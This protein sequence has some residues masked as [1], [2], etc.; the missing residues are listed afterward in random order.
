MENQISNISTD[1]IELTSSD[2]E[3]VSGGFGGGY[4]SISATNGSYSNAFGAGSITAGSAAG[5]G[6]SHAG[7]GGAYGASQSGSASAPGM[8]MSVGQGV[9]WAGGAGF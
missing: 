3:A 8:N 1:V 9:Y 5:G 4:G 6:G 2:L 7:F